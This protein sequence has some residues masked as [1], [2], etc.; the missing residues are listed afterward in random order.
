LED[1]VYQNP[2]HLPA[3]NRIDSIRRINSLFLKLSI[4]A[5]KSRLR[6][7]TIEIGGITQ[8]SCQRGIPR[9][10]LHS[11]FPDGK[12]K[13][14]AMLGQFGEQRQRVGQGLESV[15][16]IKASDVLPSTDTALGRLSVP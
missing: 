3:F 1:R 12:S 7:V 5:H 16:G 4:A 8:R 14:G 13:W 15:S 2:A 6:Q 11:S 10:S 9:L